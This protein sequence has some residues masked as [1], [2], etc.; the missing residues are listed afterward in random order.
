[1]V[2][3]F[4]NDKLKLRDTVFPPRMT[5]FGSL[6]N[7]LTDPKEHFQPTNIN[8]S[9]LPPLEDDVL[10]GRKNKKA[11]RDC[12]LKHAKEGFNQWEVLY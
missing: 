4:I 12:M 10:K 3:H 9:L 6:L 8:F 7:A 5:A 2:S 1:M 11:K